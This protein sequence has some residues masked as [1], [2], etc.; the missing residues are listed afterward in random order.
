VKGTDS[1]VAALAA[2]VT[3]I[4]PPGP[5]GSLDLD[6]LQLAE[7]VLA[8][9]AEFGVRLPDDL[10]PGTV[11]EAAAA[12]AEARGRAASSTPAL[13]DGIGHLQWLSD[14]VL[15]P[16]MRRFFTFEVV[17]ADLVP[18]HG[19]VVL[20]MNHDSALD[21]PFLMLASP[22]R[23]WFMAKHELYRGAFRGW[24]FHVLGGFPVDRAGR[25]LRAVRAGVE[26]L[27]SGRGLGMYPEGTR[28]DRFLP[29]F[30]G[31]AWM[32]ILSGAPLVPVGI[33][34]TAGAMPRGAMVPRRARVWVTFGEPLDPGREEDARA[35]LERARDVTRSLRDEVARLIR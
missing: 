9:E 13:Q 32:A 22:R 4:P 10:R 33:V 24:F 29:F 31:A 35:R 16:V 15:G 6:S 27:S 34:G 8:L 12:V 3:G 7:L 18:A 25:D 20:A 17:R 28:S 30:P 26:V 23:V 14:A 21:I 5:D 19:P 1:R 11:S 2:E